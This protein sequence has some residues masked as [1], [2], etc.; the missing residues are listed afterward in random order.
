LGDDDLGAVVVLIGV[1]GG[2]CLVGACCYAYGY[3]AA[4]GGAGA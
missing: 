3:Y 2:S 4:F 1:F